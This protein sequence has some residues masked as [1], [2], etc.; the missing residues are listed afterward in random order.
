MRSLASPSELI[1]PGRDSATMTKCLQ[2]LSVQLQ[3]ASLET[4]K[5]LTRHTPSSSQHKSFTKVAKTISWKLNSLDSIYTTAYTKS[6]HSFKNVDPYVAK[7]APFSHMWVA[8][9]DASVILLISMEL[10]VYLD[11]CW[12]T[13]QTQLYK[14]VLFTVVN[15]L[16]VEDIKGSKPGMSDWL[17]SW[18]ATL[19]T[20]RLCAVITSPLIM[21]VSWIR[22]RSLPSISEYTFL[23]FWRENTTKQF[24]LIKACF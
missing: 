15:L 23:A 2:V 12:W 5:M 22:K 4:A 19:H 9:V 24:L 3:K 8:S 17:K 7:R 11:I 1:P 16:I 21:M 18:T 6:K 10:S 14:S 20:I 13:L